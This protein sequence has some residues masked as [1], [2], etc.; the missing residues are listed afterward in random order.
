MSAGQQMIW[1]LSWLDKKSRIFLYYFNTL[2]LSE[3]HCICVFISVQSSQEE[4][5]KQ[6][7]GWDI[8]IGC[9]RSDPAN[10]KSAGSAET[11]E[12]TNGCNL[13]GGCSGIKLCKACLLSGTGGDKRPDTRSNQQMWSR[14]SLRKKLIRQK[15]SRIEDMYG[16]QLNIRK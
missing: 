1:R 8:F 2:R 9:Q 12:Q 13:Y 7:D 4:G 6:P 5:T 14:G 10:Y 11:E 3:K 15:K 16:K